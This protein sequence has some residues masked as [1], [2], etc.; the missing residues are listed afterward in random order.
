MSVGDDV[1]MTCSWEQLYFDLTKEVVW[2]KL[3]NADMRAIWKAVGKND[4]TNDAAT[5]DDLNNIERGTNSN[6]AFNHTL[7]VKNVKDD[8][9]TVYLCEVI[10]GTDAYEAHALRLTIESKY[11][12]SEVCP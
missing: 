8:D 7:L 12:H 11:F 5:S 3:Y 10:I 1:L 4:T 9:E 6:F 2:Y